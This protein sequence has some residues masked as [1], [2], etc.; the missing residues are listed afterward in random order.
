MLDILVHVPALILGRHWDV[1]AWNEGAARLMVDFDALP[2]GQRNLLWL[3]LLRPD[4]RMRYVDWERTASEAV[5]YFRAAASRHLED[6]A[7]IELIDELSLHSSEFRQLWRK[8]DVREKTSGVKAFHHPDVGLL[9]L[10]YEPLCAGEE[11]DQRLVI[12]IPED[13]DS[14]AKLEQLLR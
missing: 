14:A 1:L 8:H 7:V 5:A 6:P 2:P 12:Y 3:I 13:P 4:M 11:S 9:Q 10:R